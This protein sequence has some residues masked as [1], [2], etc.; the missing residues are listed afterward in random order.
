MPRSRYLAG[1][2]FFTGLAAAFPARADVEKT[3]MAFPAIAP[4]FASSWIAQDAGIYKEVGLEV[5]PSKSSPALARPM[6]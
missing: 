3:S 5:S 2:L 4:I 1:V 6:P